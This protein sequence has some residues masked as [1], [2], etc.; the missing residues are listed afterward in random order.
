MNTIPEWKTKPKIIEYFGGLNEVRKLVQSKALEDVYCAETR[1]WYTEKYWSENM[2]FQA[3]ISGITMKQVYYAFLE[4]PTIMLLGGSQDGQLSFYKHTGQKHFKIPRKM[5]EPSL[6]NWGA[7]SEYASQVAEP[8][9]LEFDI[10]YLEV[11]QLN[12]NR[13]LF[14]VSPELL[15]EQNNLLSLVEKNWQYGFIDRPYDPLNDE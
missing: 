6:R 5:E 12:N 8:I 14:L 2:K 4:T 10:Y 13:K 11:F 15:K 7:Y 3:N 1:K 9:T